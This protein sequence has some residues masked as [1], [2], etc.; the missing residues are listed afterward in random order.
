MVIKIAKR[1]LDKPLV[2][3]ILTA[4]LGVLVYSNTFHV[5]FYFDDVRNIVDNPLIKDMKYFTRPNAVKRLMLAPEFLLAWEVR[6]LGYL[7]LAVNYRLG[8]LDPAGYHA[9]NLVLHILNA[10]LLYVLVILFF[11]TPFLSGSRLKEQARHIALFSSLLF[12]SHPVQTQAV[13]YV[14]QRF[15]SLAAFFYL[16]SLAFYIKCRLH[17][18]LGAGSA[19]LLA[20]SVIS[21]ALAM[22]TK[23]NAFTLPAMAAMCE[24][25]FFRDSL[26]KRLVYLVPLFL[27]MAIMPLA[28]YG[29][30]RPIV[31]S[32]QSV[33]EPTLGAAE[34]SALS[35]LITQSRVIVTY[36]RLFFFPINQNLDY[37]Y[38]VFHSPA[39]GE[40]LLSLGILSSIVCLGYCLLRRSSVSEPSLRLVSLGVFWFFLALSV[41]SS[42]IPIRDVIFEHRLYLPSAGIMLA[43]VAAGWVLFESDGKAQ[44][45]FF[46][47]LT[48]SIL[49][50]SIAAYAR[51]ALWRSDVSLWR[52]VTF[53]SPRKARGYSNLASAYGSKG[54]TERAIEYYLM[55]IDLNP[56]HYMPHIGLAMMYESKGLLGKAIEHYNVALSLKSDYVPAH[57]NLGNAYDKIGLTDKAIDHYQAALKLMPDE[58]LAHYN[59]AV[60]YMSRG[61]TDAA[62][63]HYLHAIILRPDFLEARY[64]LGRIYMETGAIRKARTELEEILKIDPH[65]YNAREALDRITLSP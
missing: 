13:T 25:M 48:M 20:L 26:K 65:H 38:P 44:K 62:M 3:I 16:L 30:G 22:K 34:M 51:N 60:A 6:P 11:R 55:A 27:T 21:S 56:D 53:K 54:S 37:D 47:A 49:A 50:L 10:V 12:V 35:Y 18:R 1:L 14:V 64:N 17:D 39:D 59:L 5:P 7:T 58:E 31:E 43:F 46:L 33:S 32:I 42:I 63:E 2:H 36:L 45:I 24:F 15:T 9:F 40:V 57:I 19:V 41:E 28:I 23:E 29:L 4:A 61:M 52:D 8:G